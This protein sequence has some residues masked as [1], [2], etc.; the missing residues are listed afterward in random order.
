M[1]AF[2]YVCNNYVLSCN[3]QGVSGVDTAPFIASLSSSLN[4]TESSRQR[5][6]Q[7]Q[8]EA[9]EYQQIL[10]YIE[11]NTERA[12]EL[13]RNGSVQVDESE[14]LLSQASSSVRVLERALSSLDNLESSQL[15]ESLHALLSLLYSLESDIS[16]A[17]I[18]ILYSSLNQSLSEQK[19]MRQELENSLKETQEEVEQLRHL[20]SLLPANCDSNL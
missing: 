18:E 2:N 19:A 5:S 1:C 9:N 13:V 10:A 17:E 12:E 3:I 4:Y 20:A 6:L 15:Q 11:G 8:M 7:S 14:E 16:S